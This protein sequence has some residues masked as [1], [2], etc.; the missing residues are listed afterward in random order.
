MAAQIIQFIARRT[1][2]RLR[3]ARRVAERVNRYGQYVYPT[4]AEAGRLEEQQL[5]EKQRDREWNDR[6]GPTAQG[7]VVVAFS[8]SA[9]AGVSSS[10]GPKEGREEVGK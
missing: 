10:P 1:L 7:G 3:D 4:P 5:R 9:G 2:L 8:T 6:H